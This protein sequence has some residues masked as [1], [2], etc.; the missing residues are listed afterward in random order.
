MSA[1]FISETT[2]EILMKYVVRYPQQN[3]SEKFK[4]G[5]LSVQ[6]VLSYTK[7][8]SKCT[9]FLKTRSSYKYVHDI[10]ME[11]ILDYIIFIWNILNT[12]DI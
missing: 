12:V 9:D 4:A 1:S 11:L 6:Y 5:F 7:L 2:Q 3:L 8:K 10:N